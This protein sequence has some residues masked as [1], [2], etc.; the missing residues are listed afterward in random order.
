[1]EKR[2]ELGG[3]TVW[4]SKSLGEHCAPVE[5][6]GVVVSPGLS[7]R[8]VKGRA[9]GCC[10]RARRGTHHLKK[11]DVDFP[12]AGKNWLVMRNQRIDAGKRY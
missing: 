7:G 6:P 11:I 3:R 5:L 2:A 8:C 10:A 4:K 9:R 12:M 1:V